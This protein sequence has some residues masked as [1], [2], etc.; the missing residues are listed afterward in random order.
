[1]L[2]EYEITDLGIEKK[3]KHPAIVWYQKRHVHKLDGVEFRMKKPNKDWNE[4]YQITKSQLKDST[5][6]L[7]EKR[8]IYENNWIDKSLKFTDMVD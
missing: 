3:Y 6:H 1:M 5:K 8:V 7:D 2:K 4:T